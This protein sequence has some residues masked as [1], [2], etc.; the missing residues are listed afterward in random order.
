MLSLSSIATQTRGEDIFMSS[1]RHFIT[2]SL[3]SNKLQINTKFSSE[4]SFHILILLPAPS[5]QH[6]AILLKKMNSVGTNYDGYG[7]LGVRPHMI[8]FTPQ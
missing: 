4:I 6:K 1:T 7:A 5:L 8:K 3:Q 2:P